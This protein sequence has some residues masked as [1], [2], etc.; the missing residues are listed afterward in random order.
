MLERCSPVH[1]LSFKHHHMS[2]LEKTTQSA[3]Y[4]MAQAEPGKILHQLIDMSELWRQLKRVPPRRSLRLPGLFAFLLKPCLACKVAMHLLTLSYCL[5]HEIKIVADGA[6]PDGA[7]VFP[8]QLN[9]GITIITEFYRAQ[10]IL[11]ENPV[12]HIKQPDVE[13]F[14][15]GITK[16]KYTKNEHIYYTNQFACHVGLL[17]YLYHFL[18]WAVDKNKKKTFQYSMDFLTRGL[19]EIVSLQLDGQPG[20][21]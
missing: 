3:L 21:I 2:Q 12:Y 18:T 6:H 20:T 11:Y 17:A 5:A 14:R 7:S 19:S 1:L 10:G 8:E 16:K 4:L 13:L 15:R 9:E